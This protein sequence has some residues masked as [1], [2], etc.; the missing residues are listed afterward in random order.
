MQ[1]WYIKVLQYKYNVT[2]LKQK[3]RES[4]AALPLDGTAMYLE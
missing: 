1:C 4:M 2:F 3:C